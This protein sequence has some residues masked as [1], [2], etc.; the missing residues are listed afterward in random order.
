M[1]YDQLAQAQSDCAS[2]SL[3]PALATSQTTLHWT[4]DCLTASYFEAGRAGV[5]VPFMLPP[6]QQDFSGPAGTAN[7][8]Q[9]GQQLTSLVLSWDQRAEA[10]GITGYDGASGPGLLTACDMTRYSVFLRLLSRTPTFYGG[11]VTNQTVVYQTEIP[12]AEVFGNPLFFRNPLLINDLA[13]PL[14]NNRTYFWELSIPGL[15]TA[16][17]LSIEQLAMPSFTLQATV[18]T[19]LLATPSEYTQNAPTATWPAQTLPLTTPAGNAVINGTTDLQASFNTFDQFLSNKVQSGRG[20]ASGGTQAVGTEQDTSAYA[21]MMADQGYT[22]IIVPMW[23]GYRDVRCSE[24]PTMVLPGLSAPWTMATLDKRVVRVP[25]G[26]V[27]HHALAVQNLAS[28]PSPNTTGYAVWGTPPSSAAFSHAVGIAVNNGLRADDFA[29]QQVAYANWTPATAANIEVD[30]YWDGQA[31]TP[32]LWRMVNIPLVWPAPGVNTS[33]TA[34]GKAFFMGTSNSATQARQQVGAMPPQFGGGALQ[35]SST[36]GAENL[37]ECRW[38]IEDSINGLD[39]LADPDG[40]L[41]GTGG[42]QIILI[43]TV[44]VS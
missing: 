43:G 41:I 26:F 11:D 34:T 17:P 40:V 36:N 19:P 24:V 5:W 23:Q 32:R 6:L 18:K 12:G 27:L 2:A 35:S 29:Y 44:P 20:L 8:E 21:A 4:F 7:L 10:V 39:N 42:H 15:Y 25:D 1:V 13:I 31:V 28:P 33:F 38:L 9:Y 14:Q 22:V 30:E 37:L 16:T 3:A